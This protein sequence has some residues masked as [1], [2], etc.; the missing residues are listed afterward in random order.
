MSEAETGERKISTHD[1]L[2]SSG[3][4]AK[5]LDILHRDLF[6]SRQPVVISAIRA[7]G[8]I[9][10]PS[11][12]RYV[13]RLIS[14]KDRAVRLET[15]RCLGLFKSPA[16]VK[17]L[18]NL[19]KTSRDDD[20]RSE[21]LKALAFSAPTNPEV[22]QAIREQAVS[23]IASAEL[24]ATSAL[25]LLEL[26]GAEK[27]P[28]VLSG[29]SSEVVERVMGNAIKNETLAASIVK[30]GRSWYDRF[31]PA[32]RK[33]LIVTA[34]GRDEAEAKEIILRGIEDDDA[35]VRFAAYRA[36]GAGSWD[37]KQISAIVEHLMDNT[38]STYSLE[39]EVIAAIDRLE[40]ECSRQGISIDT[41][42]LSKLRTQSTE[43]FKILSATENRT[44]SDTIELG[45]LILR[46]REYL[47]FYAS[48]EF[49]QA[50]VHYLKG[51]SYNTADDMLSMLKRSAERVEVKHFDGYR[52]LGE[53]IKNPKR[54][55]T[56]LITREISIAKLGKHEPFGRLIRNLRLMRLAAAGG[57]ETNSL[58]SSIFS[59]AKAE[60]L[61]RLAE[62]ALFALAKFAPEE[63]TS[64]CRALLTP[65][66]ESKILT[67]AAIHIAASLGGQA[68]AN[69]VEGLL[70]GSSDSHILLNLLDALPAMGLSEEPKVVLASLELLRSGEDAEVV[71]Q[72]ARFLSSSSTPSLFENIT[73]GYDKLDEWRQRIVLEA[74]DRI[75]EEKRT[76]N[77]EGLAEFLYK[78]LRNRNGAMR[79]EAAVLLW[80]LGDDFALKVLDRFLRAGEMDLRVS[81][82]RS[83]K[84]YINKPLASSLLSLLDVEHAGLQQA[85]RATLDSVKDAETAEYIRQQITGGGGSGEL[86]GEV[87][88]EPQEE[89][90]T[91][92]VTE[93]QAYRFEHEF[94]E[95]L[96]ILF[97][98]IQG[99]SKK[100]QL[101]TTMQLTSL[102][103]DYEG[104]LLPTMETHRGTLIKKM[105]DGHLFIFRSALDAGLASLRLQKAL[106]RFNSYREEAARVIVRVGIHWGQVV[107][108]D[109]D[110]LGNHVNIASR[111]ESASKGGSVLVS[112]A[113]F[114]RFEGKIHA[115]ELGK[116]TVKNITEAIKVLEPYEIQID[117]PG[118]LD[119]LKAT[120]RKLTSGVEQEG[121]NAVPDK[122][123][124]ADSMHPPKSTL[125]PAAF[126]M[127]SDLFASLDDLCRKAE[128]KE[129]P[130]S[131]LRSEV[132]KGWE[133][134]RQQFDT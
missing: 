99:Y 102:I 128:Q 17:L 71:R 12:L 64:F 112:E 88:G 20:V 36:L 85:L 103:H 28:E 33:L 34:S 86:E 72:D 1:I 23:H 30:N 101:L 82:V 61:F 79:G 127:L 57:S 125:E 35:E 75:V 122:T 68:F 117:F 49:R 18:G 38:E 42:S 46:S 124:T 97:T 111:L 70:R 69:E 118:E 44:G 8:K 5:G 26:E 59:W 32:N 84:G 104:I 120:G 24:R 14:S 73:A 115:R 6:D 63:T 134:V 114:Q 16:V 74:L 40:T 41:S 106:K 62:A 53:I 130:V 7:I 4:G 27:L 22:T 54:P 21:T 48:Q 65:P 31:V 19:Y 66:V 100:A 58:I 45:W 92:I 133:M 110:V 80:K 126:K 78:I 132:K 81:I 107:R 108:R 105:G 131:L 129:I 15:I 37:P 55:G 89:I 113:L 83:L 11:S 25:L 116:I 47:E 39:E 10:D 76:T 87:G 109:G 121:G 2:A 56:A 43:L 123:K 3:A 50:L 29:A 95:E 93:K 91:G 60:K 77:R 67:I 90:D 9:A 94:M 119:P 13:A 52:A 51:G 98:D 96:A